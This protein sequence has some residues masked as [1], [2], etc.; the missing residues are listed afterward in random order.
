MAERNALFDA[1]ASDAI[2]GVGAP[3]VRPDAAAAGDAGL[4]GQIAGAASPA[5]PPAPVQR[6]LG[7]QVARVPLMAAQ[8]L[9]EGLARAVGAVPDFV[10]ARLGDAARAVGLP[11]IA[12]D[13]N[14]YTDL[15]RRGIRFVSGEPSAPE[16]TVEELAEAGGRSV[17][18]AASLAIPGAAVARLA[19]AGSLA[20]GVG[21]ALISQPGLQALGA[22]AGGVVGE[23]TDSPLAGLA[24]GVAAPLLARGV[25]PAPSRLNPEQM[26]LAR[27]ATQ[28]GIP[29]SAAQQT[30]SPNLQLLESVMAQMPGSAGGQQAVR[31]AQRVAWQR[32]VL[33]RAGIDAD[34]ATPEVLREGRQRLSQE[35]TDLTSRNSLQV[36]P[37]FGRELQR[38]AIEAR[39]LPEPVRP[40]FQRHVRNIL[41]GV[42]DG[43]ISGTRYRQIDSQIGRQMRSTTDG[44]LRAALGEL[45]ATLRQAMDDSISPA[46]QAAWREVRRQWSA[47]AAVRG[48]MDRGTAEAGRGMIPPAQLNLSG[49]GA[50]GSTAEGR[51]ELRDLRA[52]GQTVI[53]DPIST[54]GTAERSALGNI[55][56]NPT[57]SN[58]LLGIG[59][60][61]ALQRGYSNP[62]TQAWLTN[63]LAAGL[64][65]NANTLRAIAAGQAPAAVGE[66]TNA[67]REYGR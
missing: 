35:F 33:A 26:R 7:E 22:A 10:G 17:G 25:S 15:A 30:G 36:T 6:G 37:E 34:Y 5:P 48:A 55:I 44:D 56:A 31:D 2:A 18:E 8:G 64:S 19:P 41:S 46:D 57:I 63:Q 52:I 16:S 54:S 50:R 1:I 42:E 20:Q 21:Q 27:V 59:G 61:W 58:V 49:R 11:Q 14:F 29:L 12:P 53:R 4:F 28:E 24:A 38:V 9:N 60:P 40:A 13:P 32:A 51:G 43:A 62:T 66:G 67:L 3:P 65:P 45:Q 47:Y 39:T 23:A